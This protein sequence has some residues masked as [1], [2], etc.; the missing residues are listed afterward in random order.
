[1]GSELD[2]GNGGADGERGA[3]VRADA[4]RRG[5]GVLRAEGDGTS[6]AAGGPLVSPPIV[7]SS[8]SIVEALSK[9]TGAPQEEQNRP[10]EESCAPHEEQNIGGRDSTIALWLALA[11]PG[12]WRWGVALWEAG[13]SL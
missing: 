2:S 10:L 5:G 4:M 13:V 8:P 11:A 12:K 6:A 9:S 1:M 3:G 7:G